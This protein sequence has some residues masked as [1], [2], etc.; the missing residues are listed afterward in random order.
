MRPFA[1]ASSD[2]AES[3]HRLSASAG[4]TL[5]Q[6]TVRAARRVGEMTAAIGVATQAGEPFGIGRVSVSAVTMPALLVLS[7]LM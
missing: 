3:A 1:T 4:G 7:L 5:K 6:V 2:L